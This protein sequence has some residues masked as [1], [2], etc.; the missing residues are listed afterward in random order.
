MSTEI[1][2]HSLTHS[3]SFHN[4]RSVSLSGDGLVL[5][6]GGRNSWAGSSTG[7]AWVFQR[8]DSGSSEWSLNKELLASDAAGNDDFGLDVALSPDG[9]VA[10]VSARYDDGVA[11][12][13][14]SVYVAAAS[15][16]P[17]VLA[18]SHLALIPIPQ[19]CVHAF[20]HRVE[21]VDREQAGRQ[22]RRQLGLLW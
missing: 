3:H 4:R 11:S 12:Y 22:R 8:P 13:A 6:V 19:I 9:I 17:L 2:R 15:F 10:V 5:L 14:G 20:L 16:T 21:R 1:S 7:A 18:M